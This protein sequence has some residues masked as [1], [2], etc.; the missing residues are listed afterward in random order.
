VK[1]SGLRA[2]RLPVL[3]IAANGGHKMTWCCILKLCINN[4]QGQ[5]IGALAQHGLTRRKLTLPSPWGGEQNQIPEFSLAVRYMTDDL[6]RFVY[7]DLTADQRDSLRLR[8]Q[9]LYEAGN[10]THLRGWAPTVEVSACPVA[11]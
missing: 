3:S 7:E 11:P 4:G 5:S 8:A 9:E 6:I 10:S 2:G 1:R